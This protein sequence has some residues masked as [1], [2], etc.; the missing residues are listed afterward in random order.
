MNSDKKINKLNRKISELILPRN[1]FV[2]FGNVNKLNHLNIEC[3][4][5]I[6]S[7]CFGFL[8]DTKCF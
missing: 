1:C 6:Y 7:V 8:S 3:F 5:L 4:R 2:M